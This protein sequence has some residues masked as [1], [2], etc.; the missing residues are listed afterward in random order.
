MVRFGSKES[1]MPMRRALALF[2]LAPLLLYSVA[3]AQ[4]ATA[5]IFQANVRLVHILATVKDQN[6]SPVGSLESRNFQVAD[7]GVPQQIAVFERQTEQP[8]SIAVL[9]DDSGSTAIDLKYETDSVTRFVRAVTRSGN[10]QDTV[11]LYTFNWEVVKQTG[12]TRD[13]AAI[14]RR[15]RELNGVGGTSLFD[16]ILLASRDIQDRQGRKVLIIVTDG[17]DNLSKT[18]F[19][20]AAEAAQLADAVIFPILVMPVTN[21]AGRNIGGENA[22]TTFA[23]RTGGRVFQPT[24]G[25]AMD[26][27]FDGIL[28]DLRTQYL[29]AFYPKNVPLSTERFHSLTLTTL[30]EGANP[31]WKVS[32]RSGYYGDALPAPA[33]AKGNQSQTV[34]VAQPDE[35]VRPKKPVTKSTAKPAPNQQSGTG[36]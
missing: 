22:L 24:L 21:D 32:A 36:K 2:S 12:F 13:P 28:R 15:L 34:D 25:A 26:K 17:G 11:A 29:L 6:G 18:S 8:L 14:D 10:A 27:A 23:E 3:F 1:G 9:L 30:G 16:A 31:S 7:N 4:D 35:T 20:R 33:T 5:P 19:Q